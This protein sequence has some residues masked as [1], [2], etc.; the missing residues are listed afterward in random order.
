M[1]N[2]E[3]TYILILSQYNTILKTPDSL[4]RELQLVK[5]SQWLKQLKPNLELAKPSEAGELIEL[6]CKKGYWI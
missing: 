1:L 3:A 6:D 5:L 2:V 4:K